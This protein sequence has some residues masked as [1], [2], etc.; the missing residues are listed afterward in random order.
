MRFDSYDKGKRLMSLKNLKKKQKKTEKEW[1][2]LSLVCIVNSAE[3]AGGKS[4]IDIICN[5][6]DTCTCRNL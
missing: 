6:S 4:E 1:L 2:A 3:K 5:N